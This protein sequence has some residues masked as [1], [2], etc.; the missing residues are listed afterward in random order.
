MK[1]KNL[2][3]GYAA[4]GA[5]CSSCYQNE[6]ADLIVHNA[7]IVTVNA[8]NEIFEA[9]AI[10]DGKIIALGA[11]REILNRYSA[12]KMHDAKK[13]T[14]YPGFI[15][16]HSHFLGYATNK[17][18]LSLHGVK[19]E[20][21]L[22]ERVE[23][24]AATNQREWVVGRGW[25]HTTWAS[26]TYPTNRLLDSLYPKR[27]VIL[28]R[29]DGHA[30]LA[31]SEALRRAGIDVNTKIDGGVVM[32]NSQGAL[33]GV[34]LDAAADK[35]EAAVIPL[36][37]NLL[38]EQIGRAERECFEAGL[39]MVT[40]MGLSLRKIDFLDSLQ[41]AGNLKMPVYA[42]LQPGEGVLERMKSGTVVKDKFM[43]RGVK[44]YADGALG[45][46]GALMKRPY[47]DDEGNYGLRVLNDSIFNVYSQACLD[48]GFQLC[49]H[50]IGDSANAEI[51]SLMGDALGEMN[52][53]RWRIEHAQ[54]VSPEDRHYFTDYGIIPSMQPVHA[55]SDMAWVQ[56]RLGPE[57]EPHAYAIK[58]LK[59]TIGMLPFGTDFPVESISPIA[60]YYAAVFR[61][62]IHGEPAEGYRM[63][64]AL[65]REEALKGLTIWA[66]MA[67]FEDNRR[68][69]L[70][71]GK[72]ADFIILDRNLLKCSESEIL[73]AKVKA[74][75][76]GG[77]MVFAP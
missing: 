12:E 14:V 44:I 9:M 68:G 74:T 49:V 45:S 62:N 25:D 8:Q 57:R 64:E 5:V 11:E 67:C 56:D 39:T 50:A 26:Q 42:L 22:V 31:N 72:R 10:K 52:D 13:M 28:Q 4:L 43:V 34:L 73:R 54:V 48:Y 24:F 17:G 1:L 38:V 33:T 23:K 66:A 15:D 30:L 70:E 75:Y 60:N 77:I 59:E 27:P 3:V 41:A 7:E 53:Y 71:I 20:A 51:L 35:A 65:T 46:R 36:D 61:K 69:S 58:S 76:L 29:I 37:N 32:K 63:N 16:A 21:E 47:S 18:E 40:D 19:S 6:K 55:T 2:I